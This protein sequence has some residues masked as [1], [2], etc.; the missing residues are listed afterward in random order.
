MLSADAQSNLVAAL[1]EIERYVGT[2]GWDQPSRL[3][4]LVPTADLIQAEPTLVEQLVM[5]DPGSL[6]SIEQE[7]FREGADLATTLGRISWSPAVAGCAL[8]TERSFLPS[9][10]EHDLPADPGLAAGVVAS[11]PHRQ[12]MRVVVGVLRGGLTHGLGRF[13]TN[14]EQL[15]GSSD[16]APGLNRILMGTLQ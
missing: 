14:P 3:F 16:L 7:D 13:R 2:S 11:H 4:A 10:D 12:D 8:V 6:S 9:E 15:I 1:V 5:D